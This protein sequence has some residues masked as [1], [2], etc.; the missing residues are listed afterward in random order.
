MPVKTK[1][2]ARDLFTDLAMEQPLSSAFMHVKTAKSPHRIK[3]C[4]KNKRKENV[5]IKTFFQQRQLVN[6]KEVS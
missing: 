4:C 2:E 6:V 5:F 1:V 3:I